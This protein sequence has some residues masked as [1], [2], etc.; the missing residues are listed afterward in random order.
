MENGKSIRSAARDT[1]IPYST[2][3]I[4]VAKKIDFYEKFGQK[5][6]LEKY[7]ADLEDLI[8]ICIRRAMPPTVRDVIDYGTK[9]L[10]HFFDEKTV[11]K[12]SPL[13]R[14]WFRNFLQRHPK[15][16][17]KNLKYIDKAAVRLTESSLKSWFRYDYFHS[18]Q[19]F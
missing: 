13:S 5:P 10:H 19:C 12:H 3:Q 4:K 14:K 17:L 8:L 18:E 9:I 2:L 15:L 7:E 11:Q 6:L 16:C 1:N